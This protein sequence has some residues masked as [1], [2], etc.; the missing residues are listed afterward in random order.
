MIV[1]R[2]FPSILESKILFIHPN[3]QLEDKLV[4]GSSISGEV[5]TK[6]VYEHMVDLPSEPQKIYW[7]TQWQIPCEPKVICFIWRLLNRRLPVAD[8]LHGIYQDVSQIWPRCGKE[9]EFLNHIFF[10]CYKQVWEKA[11]NFHKYS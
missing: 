7:R 9:A 8:F 5:Q 10:N 3:Q 11:S 1:S 2:H 4:W 6:Q